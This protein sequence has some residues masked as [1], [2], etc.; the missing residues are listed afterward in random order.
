MFLFGFVSL[1]SA[2]V[3]PNPP[4]PIAVEGGSLVPPAPTGVLFFD[5]FD[6]DVSRSGT[7]ARAPFVAHGWSHAKANNTGETGACGYLYTQTDATLQSRVL[8]MEA[9]PTPCLPPGWLYGQTD[10]FLLMG[11]EGGPVV[12]PPHV[13][14]QFSTYATPDSVFAARDKFLYPCRQSYPCQPGQNS[15]LMMWGSR[16][17]EET[18][19]APSDRFIAMSS[20]TGDNRGASEYPTNAWKLYQNVERTP[21]VAGRWYQVR[22][23]IDIS[24]VQGVYEAWIRQRGATVW[25]KV[26]DWR[27]NVTPNF[28]WP[29]PPE[30]RTGFPQMATPTTVN[31]PGDSTMYIDD[32]TMSASSAS[33]P[34]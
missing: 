34:Q 18:A 26:S 4:N 23:H 7:T 29:V 14:F 17:F 30:Q 1:A 8:V 19:G 12:V 27:G 9:R 22:V 33:L 25:T 2:Q 5:N 31:G 3:R 13:W 11:R 15:W 21:I 28:T 6:Y 10:H 20:E 16:G 24:G 32:F